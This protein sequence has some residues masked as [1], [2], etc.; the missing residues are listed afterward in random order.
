MSNY[1]VHI[2][3]STK[4]VN[5]KPQVLCYK[6]NIINYKKAALIKRNK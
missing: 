6:S 2:A 5:R 1:H 4:C 3:K